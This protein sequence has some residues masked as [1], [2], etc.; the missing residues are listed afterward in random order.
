MYLVNKQ[1]I[2][3]KLVNRLNLLVYQTGPEVILI[4]TCNSLANILAKVVLPK[5]GGPWKRV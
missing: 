4:P 1:N 3:S 5:P 2:S